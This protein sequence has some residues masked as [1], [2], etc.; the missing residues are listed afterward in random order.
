[1]HLDTRLNRMSCN[2]L[3]A[4]VPKEILL[5]REYVLDDYDAH[6]SNASWINICK[7]IVNLAFKDKLKIE[8]HLNRKNGDTHIPKEILEEQFIFYNS[9]IF[10]H[11]F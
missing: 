10:I 7:K 2:K 5:N 9:Y 1:M 11:S 6:I 3:H 8:I 4:T